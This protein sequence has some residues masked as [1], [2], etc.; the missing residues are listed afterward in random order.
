MTNFGL[1][2]T[3]AGS[4]VTRQLSQTSLPPLERLAAARLLIATF[5][6][7]PTSCMQCRAKDGNQRTLH[8]HFLCEKSRDGTIPNND[9]ENISV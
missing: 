5:R 1:I 7:L 3:A 4:C 8:K 2:L 9:T 6:A